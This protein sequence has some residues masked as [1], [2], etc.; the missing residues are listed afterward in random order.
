MVEVQNPL[1]N[2]NNRQ[3][4]EDLMKGRTPQTIKME[5]NVSMSTILKRNKVG[6]G[7]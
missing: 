2:I 4:P 6:P 5:Y 1:K 3:T 7:N